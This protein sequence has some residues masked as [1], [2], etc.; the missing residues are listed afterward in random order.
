MVAPV[1]ETGHRPVLLEE[2][3]AALAI[4]EEG[5]YVD[6]TFG[7]G[8][9]ASQLLRRLG[10]GGRLVAIDRDLQAVALARS[11]AEADPR[12]SVVHGAFDRL[13]SVVESLQLHGRI[14]GVLFDLGVSSPQLDDA[15]RGFS[16]MRDGP[17]DMRM[18]SSG[19][20]TA[21]EWIAQA[22]ESAIAD[23]LHHY[24]EER[25]ARRIARAI[26]AARRSQSISTTSQLA[27]IVAR[28]HP[29]WQHGQ[30]PATRTFQAIRI[31]I[32]DELNM[33]KRGLVQALEV[34]AV[35]G[36]LLVISFHSL[37][38]RIVKQFMRR[39]S[40]KAG[41]ELRLPATRAARLRSIGKA[42]R[43]N[44]IEVAENPRARSAVLR[45]AEK[46]A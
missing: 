30:H 2:T 11:M 28:A 13:Q 7:R 19:G 3:L 32:N 8:G 12:L 10:E 31:L 24:G 17:L 5:V 22:S 16:F 40:G 14:N 6:C 37:E 1:T 4:R 15:T 27:A 21:A 43:P 36:R 44:Y 18:D 26:V 29:A 23:C 33:L 25:H 38:D 41:D 39:E 46:L 34:L 35:G 45:V 42:I 9:H 20:Q